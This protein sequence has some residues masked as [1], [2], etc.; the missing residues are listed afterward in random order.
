[1]ADSALRRAPGFGTFTP[2]KAHR[3]L[4]CSFGLRSYRREERRDPVELN[5]VL[6]PFMDRSHSSRK[7]V[8]RSIGR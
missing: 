7:K 3:F 5:G 8:Y 2:L 4:T 1:M 6:S